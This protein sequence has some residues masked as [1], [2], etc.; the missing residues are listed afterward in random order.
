MLLV[1]ALLSQKGLQELLNIAS[2]I[3]GNPMF[4]TDRSNHAI[5][6]SDTKYVEDIGWNMMKISVP[7][8]GLGVRD[9]G[10]EET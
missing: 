2:R 10:P 9:A 4:V 8:Q 7:D 6:V 5:A 1:D 3:M